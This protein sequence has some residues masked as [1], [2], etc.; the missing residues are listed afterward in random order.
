MK[1]IVEKL[2]R[3]EA[4]LNRRRA[5]DKLAAYNTGERKHE[6]QLAFHRC[7]KRNRWVFG[8]NR[9]GKTECG[10]AECVYM[11]LGIHPYRENKRDVCGW[12]VSLSAQVQR[13]VAQKKILYYL[14]RDLIEEIVMQSG[15][16]DSPENGVIDFIR[17]RN[18]FGGISVI[19]FTAKLQ[20]LE[21][22][23]TEMGHTTERLNMVCDLISQQGEL[24]D[25]D[26]MVFRKMV[27]R[28]TVDGR[29]LTY[30][31]GN[32]IEITDMV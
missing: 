28:I 2:C 24:K 21:N 20:S 4:E 27:R 11:A 3:I 6:K 13:D 8:G 32:G 15:R 16:K 26:P 12:V 29:D 7:K 18:S 25:F 5:E 14:R 31:F 19:G 23:A 22:Q 17:V 10:A 1:E 30:D 9:S